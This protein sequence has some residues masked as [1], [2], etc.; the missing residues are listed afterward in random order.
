MRTKDAADVSNDCSAPASTPG[1]AGPTT[2]WRTRPC[3][4]IDKVADKPGDA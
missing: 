3:Q 4:S 2:L 1:I